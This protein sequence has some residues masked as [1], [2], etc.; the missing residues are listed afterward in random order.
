ME[1]EIWIFILLFFVA[2]F[3]GFID[4]IA[5]GGGLI[6][7]PALI[8]VG[9]PEHVALATNKL[10][11]TFGSFTAAANFTHKKM[12]DFNSLWRGIIWTFVG[13]VCGTW[14]VLLIDAVVIKYLIPI[15]LAAI[16]IYTI[17]T[18]NLG[19]IDREK[20]ISQNLFY[21]IFGLGIGFYDGFMGPGTGSFW[22]F[23]FASLLGLNLKTA[24]ANTKILNFT[25]NIVSLAVFIGGGQILWLLGIVMGFGQMIGAY[26]G[27]HMVIKKEI[28]FIKIIFLTVVS[29]T[30]VKI[31]Y[32]LFIK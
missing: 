19:Q 31:I 25:S 2:F 4:A 16:L 8:A 7:I 24:V 15:C 1:L 20:R 21:A 5:G 32:D 10:Q 13:A 26:F 6:T 23:A 3:S 30:I 17:F 12:V 18:P 14:S 28:K 9:I 27:S 22:M 11:A 29:L